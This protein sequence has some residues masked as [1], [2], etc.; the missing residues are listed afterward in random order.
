MTL[1]FHATRCIFSLFSCFW[2]L[3]LLPF[4]VSDGETGSCYLFDLGEDKW[5]TVRAYCDVVSNSLP[6]RK[7][8]FLKF[9]WHRY[10]DEN[11][12]CLDYVGQDTSSG[13]VMFSVVQGD[14]V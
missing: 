1:D 8:F 9:E 2:H 6:R 3:T 10:W 11:R 4:M 12:M 5:S 13:V 14:Y 7:D